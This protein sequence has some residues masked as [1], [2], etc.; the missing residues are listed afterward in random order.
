MFVVSTVRLASEIGRSLSH[1]V[2]ARTA[3]VLGMWSTNQGLVVVGTLRRQHGSNAGGLRLLELCNK[4]L[5][6]G[7][8]AGLGLDCPGLG[9][10]VVSRVFPPTL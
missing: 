2:K 10:V 3:K 7:V 4:A 8:A 6:M 5:A 1:L 9:G